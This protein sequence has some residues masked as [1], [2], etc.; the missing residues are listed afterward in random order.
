MCNPLLFIKKWHQNIVMAK[1]AEVKKEME[2]ETL[3]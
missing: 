2:M 1:L 3:S